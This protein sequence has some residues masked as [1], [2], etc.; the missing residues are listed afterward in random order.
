MAID[1]ADPPM[2]ARAQERLR[3]PR[4]RGRF[5][6]IEAARRR[7]ALLE[8]SDDRGQALA[9]WLVEPE[10]HEIRDSRFLAF[11]ALS[12][13]PIADAF[14]ETVRGRRVADAA[15]VTP[16]QLDALL[17]DDP[18]T[19]AVADPGAFAFIRSLQ[20]RALEAVPALVVLPPPPD[21]PAYVRKRKADWTP[22][23]AAWLP[24]S[25]LAKI[26]AVDA[27]AGP[28]L[29]E[30]APGAAMAID[31]LHDDLRLVV[32]LT[33][34]D[35]VAAPTLVLALRDRLRPSIHPELH[36]ELAP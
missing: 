1:R 11:G 33:G 25:L 4:T 17:R 20:E 27:A 28:I 13:H 16:E 26:A 19:P 8:V 22:Q 7:L 29:A 6:P 35:A 15:A 31:G 24:K 30:V 10:T 23:D 34:V 14:T 9:S 18:L 21:A 32:R 12:S 5:A 36:V 3:R 2:S